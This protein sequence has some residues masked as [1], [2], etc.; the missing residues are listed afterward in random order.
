MGELVGAPVEIGIGQ[1]FLARDSRDARHARDEGNAGEHRGRIRREPCLSGEHLV[2]AGRRRQLDGG[3]VPLL[4]GLRALRGG[5]QRQLP[6]G[7]RRRR[8][9]LPQQALEVAQQARRG[10][11]FEQVGV[12][13]EAEAERAVVGRRRE[14]EIELR[15]QRLAG[16]GGQGESGGVEAAAGLAQREGGERLVFA[17]LRSVQ[18]QHDLEQRRA[19]RVTLALQPLDEEGKG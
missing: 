4:K 7:H 8:H 14:G 6:D 12:V 15:R 5:Q 19:R 13:L 10:D 2:Q 17:A 16:E 11:A 3:V 1:P 9:R 18:H